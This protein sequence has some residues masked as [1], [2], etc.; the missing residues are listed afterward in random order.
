MEI[1]AMSK[2]K[3]Q[4]SNEIQSPNDKNS[5]KEKKCFDIEPF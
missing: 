4:S 2:F 3:F 1:K 5:T